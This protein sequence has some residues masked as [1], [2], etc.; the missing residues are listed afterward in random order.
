[1]RALGIGGGEQDAHRPAL[2][3]SEQRGA[4]RAGGVHHRADVVHAILQ[5]RRRGDRVGKP[6]AALVEQD[7][8]RERGELVEEA[9]DPRVRPLQVQVRDEARHEHE[10]ERTVA[11]D[12]VGDVDLT[13][14]RVVGLRRHRRTHDIRSG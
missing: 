11:D 6:R 3:E 4:L 13:A 8:P 1:M 10:V 7:Q 12:L 9:R 5:R 14:L 2:R